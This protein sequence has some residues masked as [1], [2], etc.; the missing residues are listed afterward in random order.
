M[1]NVQGTVLRDEGRILCRIGGSTLLDAARGSEKSTA[2][3]KWALQAVYGRIT[4]LEWVV[5]GCFLSLQDIRLRVCS[6]GDCIMPLLTRT[7]LHYL[8]SGR[9]VCA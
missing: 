5:E 2:G 8:P 6:T 4:A 1:F 7:F 3:V 9:L